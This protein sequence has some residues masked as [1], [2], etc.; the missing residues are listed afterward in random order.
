MLSWP[1]L[2][3]PVWAV[4][5]WDV[6]AFCVCLADYQ[7]IPGMYFYKWSGAPGLSGAWLCMP[8]KFTCMQGPLRLGS[9][10]LGWFEITGSSRLPT[11]SCHKANTWPPQRTSTHFYHLL[12]WPQFWAFSVWQGAWTSVCL[13]IMSPWT[14]LLWH[15]GGICLQTKELSHEK[16]IFGYLNCW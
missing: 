12:T 13:G 7:G 8:E 10:C 1:A 5:S 6:A 15:K 11:F 16:Q 3:H 14:F 9:I 2:G 4:P